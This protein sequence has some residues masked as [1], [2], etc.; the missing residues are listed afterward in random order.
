MAKAICSLKV[1]RCVEKDIS[2][3]RGSTIPNGVG[4]EGIAA[5]SDTTV[6]GEH[7][8]RVAI[9]NH[10]TQREDLDIIVRETLRL[11]VLLERQRTT[12]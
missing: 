4:K 10:R 12:I 8:L 11:G 3:L 7:C 1:D 5:L 6:H 9:D 2:R